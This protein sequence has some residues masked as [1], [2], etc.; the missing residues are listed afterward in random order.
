MQ[1]SRIRFTPLALTSR[2]D[3]WTAARQIK[4]I[5]ELAATK[6]LPRA[7]KAV[8]MSRASAYKLRDHADAAEIRSAW[9][10]ALEPEFA[11]ERRRS[12]AP[13]SA[14]GVWGIAQ[15]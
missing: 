6:S 13:S 8:G 9:R 5:E 7:C 11:A 14:L 12:P 10:K 15:S 4:F 1:P 3:G 2:H